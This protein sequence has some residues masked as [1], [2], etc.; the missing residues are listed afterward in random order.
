MFDYYVV[1][2]FVL[3]VV[4]KMKVVYLVD[5]FGLQLCWL[6]LYWYGV[7][8]DVLVLDLVFVEYLWQLFELV[9]VE[10]QVFILMLLIFY[11]LYQVQCCLYW[12]DC[13]WLLYDFVFYVGLY[14]SDWVN[15]LCC[16]VVLK[17]VIVLIEDCLCQCVIWFDFDV[18]CYWWQVVVYDWSELIFV[19]GLFYYLGI[20]CYFGYVW[21]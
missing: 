3:Y 5:V 12:L 7:Q 21:N 2:N 15:Y 16:W 20:V 6:C 14:G 8:V 18:V 11:I 13:Y 1:G 19:Y 17:L 4:L 10:I 9:W